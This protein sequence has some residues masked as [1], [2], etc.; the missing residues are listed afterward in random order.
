[1]QRHR[2]DA[3]EA[4]VQR[5]SA[6]GQIAKRTRQGADTAVFVKMNEL[7]RYAVVGCDAV[8]RVEAAPAGAAKSAAALLV[9][10]KRILKRAPATDA[11]EFRVQRFRRGEACAA[12][13]ITER[14]AQ[15]FAA[16]AA[17]IWEE[18]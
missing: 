15:V 12:Y 9:Q 10:R 1:V 3:I 5:P 13:G 2:H 18:E 17:V 4:L 8:S 11:E 6:R 7:A 14:I 16:N